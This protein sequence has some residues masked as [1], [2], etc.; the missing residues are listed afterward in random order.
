MDAGALSGAIF[1]FVALA[2]TIS[3]AIRR[4]SFLDHPFYFA[5]YA[6]IL[7]VGL[8]PLLVGFV[9]PLSIVFRNDVYVEPTPWVLTIS[10]MGSGCSC[11]DTVER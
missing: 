4:R 8:P 11:A 7:F 9:N 10:W 6:Y 1:L 2:V 5:F 3:G